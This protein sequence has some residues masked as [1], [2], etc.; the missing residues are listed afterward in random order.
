M[1]NKE[2]LIAMD[3]QVIELLPNAKFKVKLDQGTII[4]AYASGKIQQNRIKILL[5]DKVT[6]EISPYNIA[7]G[8]I[9]HR[10]K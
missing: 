4:D 5:H 9:T 1:S 2:D 7:L 10:H 6:V 3:G 8:R